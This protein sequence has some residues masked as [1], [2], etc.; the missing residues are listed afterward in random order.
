MT[1]GFFF[2]YY[3]HTDYDYFYSMM[4]W[5]IHPVSLELKFTW[6]I[7]RNTSDVKHN[8]IVRVSDG[9]FSGFGEA[10]PNIRYG[11]SSDSLLEEFQIFLENQNGTD[12]LLLRDEMNL[13]Y[14]LRFAIDSAWTHLQA[15]KKNQSIPQLKGLATP[16][17]IDTAFTIPIMDPAACRVFYMEN[18]LKRFR[19][20]KL[21]IKGTEGYDTLHYLSTFTSG[22]IILDPNESFHDV[23][24][25]I[26]FSE[27]IRKLPVEF[28][29]QPMPDGMDIEYRYL[30]KYVHQ[31]VFA[32][33]SIHHDCDFDRLKEMFDG[34][35]VKLMKAGSYY[36][37]IRQLQMA[38]ERKMGT[39]IGCMVETTLGIF[40][41][42][43]L[44]SLCHYADLDSFL[45]IK[46]EPF[47]M[48]DEDSGCLMFRNSGIPVELNLE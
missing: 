3:S 25:L 4:R 20:V 37:A 43:N 6:K 12:E 1:G 18:D 9:K 15:M 11:E 34:I 35:N 39:M 41:G 19:Y 16:E 40:S 47:Q 45:Y 27:K 21:K 30:K 32:D 29:E 5:S 31:P 23:D 8:L 14:A 38:R 17:Q 22:R 13:S 2:L 42:M 44:T 7:S 28:L 24:E 46:K 10:A 33:E 26:R 48:I 36:T